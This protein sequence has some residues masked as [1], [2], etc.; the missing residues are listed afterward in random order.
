ME[1]DKDMEYF[2]IQMDLNMR[3]NGKMI[4]KMVKLFL[5]MK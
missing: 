3:V 2:I 4:S 1:K 5:T